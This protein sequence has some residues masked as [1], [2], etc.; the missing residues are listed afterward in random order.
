MNKKELRKTYLESRNQ[1]DAYRKLKKEQQI[2][3]YFFSLLNDRISCVH[4]Y[5]P[6]AQKN[7]FDTWPLIQKLW[8]KNIQ[9]VVPGMKAGSVEMNALQLNADSLLKDA[10]WNV[11][12]PADG[13]PVDITHIDMVVLPMLIC[14]RKGHRVGYGKGYY[15]NFLSKFKEKGPLKV[16]LCFFE[17]VD[18]IDDINEWD[19]PLDLC[20]TPEAVFRF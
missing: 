17:P 14:D 7:E 15:D 11:P 19:V 5:L 13:I 6:I 8:S 9:V 18:N 1:L 20:I 10:K 3:D 2:S 4:I 12:E 16:G